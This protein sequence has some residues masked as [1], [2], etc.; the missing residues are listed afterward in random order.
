MRHHRASSLGV[1][2]CFTATLAGSGLA[3]VV[4]TVGPGGFPQI[5]NAIAAANPGDIVV[6]QAG[7]YLAFTLN[8][9]LTV[10]AAPAATVDIVASNPLQSSVTLL[11]PPT[12]AKVAGLRFL[13]LPLFGASQV[14]VL[15]GTVHCAD[16]V[17]EGAPT[18]MNAP[19][20]LVVQNAEVALQRCIVL[21][22][23]AQTTIAGGSGAGCDGMTVDTATVAA[24]DSVFLGGN[25]HWD[26]LGHGGH[27]IVAQ[28]ADLHLANCIAIGG[29]ND[30]LIPYHAPGNGLRI[31]S[32]SRVWV[33]DCLIR[34]GNGRTVAGG[35][36]LHNLG[37]TAVVEA[38]SQFLG[39]PGSPVG[40]SVIGPL[41]TGP[42]LGLLGATPAIPLG[43]GWTVGYLAAPG[44]PVLVI[45]S[46]RLATSLTPLLA[47]PAWMPATAMLVAG[48]GVTDPTG[49]LPFTF[50]VPPNPALLHAPCFVQG[51]AGSTLPLR[52]APPVGG[53]V[54]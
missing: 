24:V 8:K 22:G 23:G 36:A 7:S 45:A 26:F 38:R 9:D 12:M 16:C 1:R 10:T 41:V 27:A 11:Q 50:A 37:A 21:G 44:T 6:V 14:R 13:T 17:F 47:E 34:G 2:C 18:T 30:P 46:D 28:A 48:A 53:V 25:I 51:I 40:P 35:A 54:R 42:L 29:G 4:H 32:T 52:A 39:G 43:A 31:A 33:A 19:P 20:A 49:A 5:Q 15:G 3:Q